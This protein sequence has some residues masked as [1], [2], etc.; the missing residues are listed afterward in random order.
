MQKFINKQENITEEMLE[1][2]VLA[3][4][5]LLS[6][7]QE[8]LIVNKQLKNAE[9]VAVVT[10]DAAGHEPAPAGFVGEGMIDIAVIGDMFTAP[11]PKSCLEALRMADRG[12]G[13]LLVVPN[14]SGILLTAE[15]A[16][17][18][19]VE[20][21]IDVKKV[22]VAEDVAEASRDKLLE[23]RGLVG[24]MAVCKIAG[25]VAAS[26]KYLAETAAIVQ[27]FA[28]N[29]A[30]VAVAIKGGINPVNAHQLA[31]VE[32]GY[33]AVGIGQDGDSG[34][35]EKLYSAD[36]VAEKLLE[37]LL[38]DLQIQKEEKVLLL[39]NGSGAT[40]LA[41]LLIIFRAC[42]G[43]LA[44]KEIRVSSVKIG[45]FLT[46]QDVAGFQL[47]MARMDDEL[48]EYWNASCCTPY[49]RN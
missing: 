32:E 49:Y 2:L 26:G 15:L 33:M 37:M 41:E 42:Y 28:D 7:E 19:A 1:G 46:V 4:Q 10:L 22:I 34:K 31:S 12:H 18:K 25:A 36:T 44:E 14:H 45:E 39:V 27:R 20:L 40:T 38:Q 6:L 43:L 21:G 24:C 16:V 48:L 23:R 11:G 29:L 9:R 13:V 47:C 17:K 8:N 5:Q 30:T 3:N 35:V